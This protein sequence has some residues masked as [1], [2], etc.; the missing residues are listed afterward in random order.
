L[1]Q[2]DKELKLRRLT[3]RVNDR[4]RVESREMNASAD[5]SGPLGKRSLFERA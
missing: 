2:H 1:L 5:G 3:Q 4:S